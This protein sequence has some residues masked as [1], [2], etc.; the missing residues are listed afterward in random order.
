MTTLTVLLFTRSPFLS[1]PNVNYIEKQALNR[2]LESSR[3]ESSALTFLIDGL[4]P[5]K[6]NK[7]KTVKDKEKTI[8]KRKAFCARQQVVDEDIRVVEAI[9]RRHRF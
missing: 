2:L 5:G 8:E 3:R 6:D 7:G 9:L 1:F 4:K